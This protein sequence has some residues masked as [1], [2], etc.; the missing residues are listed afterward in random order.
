MGL[1]YANI[2][3]TNH[4]DQVL[5]EQNYLPPDKIRK[6]NITALVD[7]GSIMLAINEEVQNKLGLRKM[8]NQFVSMA[9]GDRQA[10]DIV[11]PVELKFE[12]RSCIVSAFLL[13]GN[14]EVL[15]GA[16]P[17]EYMDVLID[18]QRQRLIVNPEHPDKPVLHMKNL[19]R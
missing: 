6:T 12:N 3:L 15:L 17:M 2:E 4:S 8:G 11:G 9:N 5:C 18:P 7:T 13:P 16:I 10:L 19:K 1:V 14:S